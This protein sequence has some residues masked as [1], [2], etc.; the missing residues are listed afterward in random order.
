MSLVGKYGGVGD[1]DHN[2]EWGI[3]GKDRDFLEL[4][5]KPGVRCSFGLG[6]CCQG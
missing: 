1:T 5:I 4:G 2:T 6:A 3:G